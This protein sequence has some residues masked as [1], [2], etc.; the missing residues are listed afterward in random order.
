MSLSSDSVAFALELFEPVGRISTRK[1]MGGLC[2]Y[3]DGQI[4]AIVDRQGTFFL[5]A[6]GEFAQT[7][8]AAG[9]RQFGDE[10]SDGGRM[11]Y[12]TLPD[13]GLDDP[14][15]ASDWARKALAHL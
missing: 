6:K 15:T 7:L 8:S 3:S 12:W 10:D 2:I 9:S 13:D 1:M 11:G 5:K 4:F 14:E